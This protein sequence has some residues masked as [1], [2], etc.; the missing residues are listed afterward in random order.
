MVDFT[1]AMSITASEILDKLGRPRVAKV[2]G[3]GMTAI[4]RASVENS[5]PASWYEAIRT[6]CAEEQ[7]SCPPDLFKQKG[8]ENIGG[9]VA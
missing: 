4:S 6:L 8:L 5:F 3:V 2:L 1:E 7:L 9:L